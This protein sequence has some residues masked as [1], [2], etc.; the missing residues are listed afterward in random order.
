MA[1]VL[2]SEPDLLQPV[3]IESGLAAR[4]LN[5]HLLLYRE[6][7]QSTNI[8][9]I[10][11]F[12]QT[13]QLSI[14]TCEMQSAGKGRRGRRWISPFARNIYCTVGMKKSLPSSH[15]GLLSI[16]SGIALSRA[17]A[18]CDIEAVQLKWPND[19]V[20]GDSNQKQKLGGILIESR[21]VADGYFLAI[22]FGLNVHMTRAELDAIPQAATSL[23]LI[24]RKKLK[25]QA[26]LM[27]AIESLTEAIR[28]FNES[29]ID[30]LVDEFAQYDA[31]INQQVCVLHADDQITGINKGINPGGQLLLKTYQGVLSFS[32]AEIS[33]RT[34]N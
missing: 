23:S 13:G 33:L 17:L 4:G 25:R 31:Y 32:A 15:L 20:F 30:T 1:L 14:A 6:Q 28:L 24:S 22:G 19:L 8:D 18:S 7:T 12:E 3:E 21:P 27:A 29:T 11:H 5:E 26:I 34:I 2:N 9:V 16:V 10:K